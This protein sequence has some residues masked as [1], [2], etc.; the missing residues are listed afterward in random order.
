MPALSRCASPLLRASPRICGNHSFS[1]AIIIIIIWHF[2]TSRYSLDS[3]IYIIRTTSHFGVS[4]TTRNA[5]CSRSALIRLVGKWG[6]AADGGTADSIARVS[7]LFAHPAT[8]KRGR[9]AV[10]FG[11]SA[12]GA[13]LANFAQSQQLPASAADTEFASPEALRILNREGQVRRSYS[14]PPC[15]ALTHSRARS[16]P[17]AHFPTHMPCF[18]YP[19]GCSQ[20]GGVAVAALPGAVPRAP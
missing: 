6:Q 17:S 19:P 5:I 10:L 13:A 16:L 9:R 3:I 20:Q 8:H 4:L 15:L 2:I 12:V 7:P 14:S 1:V 11:A 18:I